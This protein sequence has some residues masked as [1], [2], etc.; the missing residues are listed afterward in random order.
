MKPAA[1]AVA[2]I[3]G[4]LGVVAAIGFAQPDGLEPP[5]GPIDDTQPSLS[6][7]SQ[8]VDALAGSGT[9]PPDLEFAYGQ[10]TSGPATI[11]PASEG[12]FVRLHSVIVNNTSCSVLVGPSEQTLSV[13]SGNV[14]N[15]AA[16]RLFGT[17]QAEYAGLVVPT[18]V[19]INGGNN[20]A[21]AR[22]TVL[23]W[24]E[25]DAQ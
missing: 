21:A 11:I 10:F 5:A 3:A 16:E 22:V 18:P 4:T 8:Q 6:S 25:G 24:V 2:S 23:Y 13:L 9:F 12:P 17:F 1:I 19:K 20:S 7:I 15:Q 14:F